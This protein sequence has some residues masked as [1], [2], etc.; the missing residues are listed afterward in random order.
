MKEHGETQR[1]LCELSPVQQKLVRL[2][3]I[4]PNRLRA[5]KRKCAGHPPPAAAHEKCSGG[6]ET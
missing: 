5:F 3:G 4:P 2:L 1:R 6:C